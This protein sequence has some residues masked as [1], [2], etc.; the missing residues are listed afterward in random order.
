M[1]RPVRTAGV[2]GGE[3]TLGSLGAP[4]VAQP[5]RTSVHGW[6]GEERG[7]TSSE[8]T[9]G[10]TSGRGAL[11]GHSLKTPMAQCAQTLGTRAQGAETGNASARPDARTQDLGQ[12]RGLERLM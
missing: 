11:Q 1:A 12:A 5:C 7:L 9:G 10:V 3:R 8:L 6:R 4:G 2:T